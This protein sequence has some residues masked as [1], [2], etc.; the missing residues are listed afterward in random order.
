MD[1]NGV[2]R[3]LKGACESAGV[4]CGRKNG[5]ITFHD[6]RRTVKS[7]ILRAGV[8]KAYRDMI[9]G[10]SLVGM[11]VHYL[12][13]DDT[14]LHEAMGTYTKWLDAQLKAAEAKLKSKSKKIPKV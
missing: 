3:A 5:G 1:K 12:V 9:L 13:S 7:N 14:A 4:P 11:D 10:H 6:I 8:D 2:K